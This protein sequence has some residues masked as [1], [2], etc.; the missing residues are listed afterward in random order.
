MT[1]NKAQSEIGD[2]NINYLKPFLIFFVME[3]N[4]DNIVKQNLLVSMQNILR[5]KYNHSVL[6]QKDYEITFQLKFLVIRF[7]VRCK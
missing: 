6:I 7:F 3:T 4:L 2:T 5:E 1:L